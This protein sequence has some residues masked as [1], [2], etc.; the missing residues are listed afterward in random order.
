M[1]K[2]KKMIAMLLCSVMMVIAGNAQAFAAS[3]VQ[4]SIAG[5]E[6]SGYV[7]IDSSSATAVTT[8]TRGGG[9]RYATAKVYYWWGTN[10]YVS[11]TGT[12]SGQTGGLSVTATKK[13]GGAEVVG[14]KGIHR[15]EYDIYTW[16]DAVTETGVIP[17]LATEI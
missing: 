11:S 3:S 15:V 17:S 12:S 2:R 6:V 13:Y 14:G 7:T 5:T 4:G 10:N 9:K 8:F 1:G 16:G